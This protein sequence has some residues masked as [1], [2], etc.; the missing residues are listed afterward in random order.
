M[1]HGSSAL[2]PN[3]GCTRIKRSFINFAATRGAGGGGHGMCAMDRRSCGTL[4]VQNRPKRPLRK[5]EKT[6]TR[7]SVSAPWLPCTPLKRGWNTA[8]IQRT[9]LRPSAVS[10]HPLP[11]DVILRIPVCFAVYCIGGNDIFQYNPCSQNQADSHTFIPQSAALHCAPQAGTQRI[12]QLPDGPK[13]R[14][15]ALLTAPPPARAPA[16]CTADYID[17]LL[18][19]VHGT[20]GRHNAHDIDRAI[21]DRR[22][23]TPQVTARRNAPQLVNHE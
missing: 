11:F 22:A 19:G 14:I 18:K 8:Q 4:G 5:D 16:R 15:L 9:L 7:Y 20:G 1:V 17:L 2:L 3:S 23:L 13:R 6:G 10:A 21:F 12:P